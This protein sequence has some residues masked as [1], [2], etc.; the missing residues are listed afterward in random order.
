MSTGDASPTVRIDPLTGLRTIL[1]PAR[2]ER[3]MDFGAA[4][5]GEVSGRACPFCEGNEADTPEEIWADRPDGEANRPGWRVRSVP[6]LYPALLRGEGASP[7]KANAR[8][9]RP[10]LFESVPADGDHEVIV[11]SPQHLRALSQ[12]DAAGLSAAVAGWRERMRAHAERRCVQLIVNE[13]P[14]A[15]ASLEHTHSQLYAMDFVPAAVARE[16]ER[17]RSYHEETNGGELLADIVSEEIR[18]DERV[19]AVDDEAVLVCPWASRSPFELRLI[20]RET[21][22]DFAAEQMD[23]RAVGMLATA[24]EALKARFGTEPQL[25]LWVRTAP[26]NAEP[27]HWHLDIAPRLAVRAS[28][29]I[30]T[31]VEINIFP[32]ERAASELRDALGQG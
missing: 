28:Y 2:A 7:A 17:F 25:N 19:V 6:N 13:G 24:F 27:F 22:G 26:K 8:G 16:R 9:V 23:G 31:G 15:G 1:A 29:E 32:P 30:A 21:V 18:R 12:M 20:P 10:E 14:D 5:H 4:E 11:H 3:P